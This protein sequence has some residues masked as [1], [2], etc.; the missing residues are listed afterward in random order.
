MTV[1]AQS[2]FPCWK[3]DPMTPPE[4]LLLAAD[5]LERARAFD[6][7]AES[8]RLLRDAQGDLSVTAVGLL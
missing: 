3:A 4:E 7:A 6:D 2:M 1:G 8:E 5:L